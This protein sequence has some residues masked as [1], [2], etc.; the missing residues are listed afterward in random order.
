MTR[1]QSFKAA[2]RLQ[3]MC[4]LCF[5][6]FS[7]LVDDLFG[8]AGGH[9][10]DVLRRYALVIGSN[11]GG[12]D[13]VTLLYAT[14]DAQSFSRVMKELG[15]VRET[16]SF[17]LLDPSLKEIGEGIKKMK[18]ALETTGSEKQR[19]EFILYY[20]GH[21]DEEGL[22]LGNEKYS[23]KKFREDMTTIPASVRIV[24][25]DSC[26]SGTLTR[27]KGGVRQPAFL[28]DSAN[29]MKGQAIL[30]S[31]S[32]KEAAQE[33]D[34]IK[35]SFFTHYLISGLRGAAD[36]T[37]DGFVTLNEAYHYAFK[38]TLYSTEKTQLGPQH[39]AYDIN[40]S[41]TGDLVLTDLREA[42]AS[43][44]VASEISGRIFFRD[45][46]GQLAVEL[47]KQP[48]QVIQLGL[49]PGRYQ[50]I[51]DSANNQITNLSGNLLAC[52][53]LVKTEELN[54]LKPA[55]LKPFKGQVHVSRG[56]AANTQNREEVSLAESFLFTPEANLTPESDGLGSRMLDLPRARSFFSFTLLPGIVFP[57]SQTEQESAIF[58]LG[59]LFAIENNVK[60]VQGSLL[61][62]IARENLHGV[63]GAFIG[64]I[65]GET[66]SGWQAAGLFNRVK[67]DVAGGQVAGLFN[68]VE[69]VVSG[70]QMAGLFN[71]AHEVRGSQLGTINIAKGTV[72]G[73][74][75]GL[76][77]ICEDIDGVPLGLIN[78][79]KK[80]Q[81]GLDIWLDTEN[82]LHAGLRLGS[83]Y[84]YTL[85]TGSYLRDSNPLF[86][87]YG[88][89]LGGTCVLGKFFINIDALNSFYQSGW[90]SK[91]SFKDFTNLSFIPEARIACG[92]R[93]FSVIGLFGGFSAKYMIP[94]YSP[95]F[96][97]SSM[98]LV[99]EFSI[100]PVFYAGV[101]IF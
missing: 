48:G 51:V 85:F 59:L 86:W 60:A 89:G 84:F 88:M 30:T 90:A 43:I 19:K 11:N 28:L 80:G 22:L 2:K 83:R 78:I 37:G 6:L 5:I 70:V 100:K 98:T 49:M 39:P 54:Q 21:S 93:L 8:Q 81:H 61:I 96:S 66:V 4:C 65:T 24:I 34:S 26:Y 35:A 94:G 46:R 71:Y 56:D 50:V 77:N 36:A 45:A 9:D 47:S 87:S 74:Q 31:S 62:N 14:T 38:E 16:D 79:V 40:L 3:V 101:Q 44:I 18:G 23:Y 75:L 10:N 57:R 95:E 33:S 99:E 73:L 1:I 63:Q 25:L 52:E 67:D 76:V 32:D 7:T 64:N 15:G 68:S 17:L 13:R 69:G 72:K 41:G 55:L 91:S 92:L 20:S 27:T 29:E 97:D 12:P 53:L 42:S 58:S 82:F